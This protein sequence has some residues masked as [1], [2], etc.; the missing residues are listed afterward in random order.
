MHDALMLLSMYTPCLFKCAIKNVR[1]A[2][3]IFSK[4]DERISAIETE[5]AKTKVFKSETCIFDLLWNANEGNKHAISFLKF[6]DGTTEKAISRVE[7]KL[8]SA[9]H[10]IVIKMLTSFNSI[11][12]GYRYFLAELS[13]ITKITDDPGFHLK[14]VEY[15]L[16]NGCKIDFVFNKASIDYYVEVYSL[17]F[18][19]EKID[20]CESLTV[21]LEK[22]LEK[23]IANKF[24]GLEKMVD[25]FLVVPVLWG[26]TLNLKGFISTFEH[27]KQYRFVSP[28]MFIPQII[29]QDTG[30]VLYDFRCIYPVS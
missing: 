14:A 18:D 5:I 9:V 27:F 3:K 10:K 11:E 15:K 6:I 13:V 17:N 24:K 4:Y 16:K 1:T 22:R 29:N 7:G 19:I 21:F 28:F 26:D 2:E 12:S 30:E 20:S 8:K 23:K 25:N